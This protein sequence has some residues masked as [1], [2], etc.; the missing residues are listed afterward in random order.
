MNLSFSANFGT[1]ATPAKPAIPAIPTA[2][3]SLGNL[4]NLGNLGDV[5]SSKFFDRL[6]SVPSISSGIEAVKNN[7]IMAAPFQITQRTSSLFAAPVFPLAS[8]SYF[9]LEPLIRP[10]IKKVDT[11]ATDCI[12]KVT[13]T[14]PLITE[15]PGKIVSEVKHLV[16]IPVNKLL[17]E[18]DYVVATYSQECSSHEH[19]G[20]LAKGRAVICT[21]LIVVSDGLLWLKSILSGGQRPAKPA[22]VVQNNRRYF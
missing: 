2:K 21:Q 1:P 5:P 11:M 10:I 4:G 15:E 20:V 6:G 13:G 3:G 7:P 8:L 18:K 12:D 16:F 9:V 14:I 19:G 17:E 22:V